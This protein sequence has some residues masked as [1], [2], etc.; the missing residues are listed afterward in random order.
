[1]GRIVFTFPLSGELG[2]PQTAEKTAISAGSD[3]AIGTKP[4]AGLKPNIG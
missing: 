4:H 2:T 1:V 3:I